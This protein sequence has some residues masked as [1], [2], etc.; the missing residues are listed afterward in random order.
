L[1]R[2][3]PFQNGNT[4]R[5]GRTVKERYEIKPEETARTEEIK[6]LQMIM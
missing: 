1:A 6:N 3:L 2:I 5:S 4:V